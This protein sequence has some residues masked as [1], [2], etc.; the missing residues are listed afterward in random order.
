MARPSLSSTIADTLKDEIKA[1]TYPAGS[2]LPSENA[3]CE[4]FSVSRSTIRSAIRELDAIGIITTRRGSGS[5]VNSTT[6]IRAGLQELDSITRSIRNSG[7][8]PG[9]EFQQP[10]VRSLTPEEAQFAGLDLN[11]S[12]VELRRIITGDGETLAYSYDL[13]PLELLPDNFELSKIQGSIFEF[14]RNELNIHPMQSTAD[15]HAVHSSHIAW[16][17]EKAAH[18]LFLQLKQLHYDAKGTLILYSRTYFIEG[19]YTFTIQRT[20]V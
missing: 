6:D 10:Q 4:Q 8:V 14:F 13:I 17:K 11:T 1:G 16:G 3:L 12:V 18:D 19:R 2:K 20:A 15:V 7:K 9:T 5:Y